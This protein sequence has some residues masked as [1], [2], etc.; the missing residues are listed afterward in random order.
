[1][2]LIDEIVITD[3]NREAFETVLGITGEHDE[4][5]RM[6]IYGPLGTGKSTVLQARGREKDLLSKK[7]TLFCNAAELMLAVT[8]EDFSEDYL[9]KAGTVDV[10]L[11]DGFEDFFTEK[12][13]DMGPELC[14]LLLQERNKLG[15]E[16]VLFSNVA[17]EE[18]DAGKLGTTLDGY[19]IVPVEPLD[20]EGRVEFARKLMASFRTDDSKPI[21]ADDA[22]EY[23]ATSFA[24]EPGDIRN[25]LRYLIAVAP[26][27]AGTT[28]TLELAKEALNS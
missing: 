12:A 23:I 26:F 21:V 14:R 2:S 22:L 27:E 10:L 1:M 7:S 28:I 5:V 11:V 20:A 16:T 13:G 6:F 18:V 25:A 8:L 19:R 15:L 3:G 24:Q 4:P 17:L 9:K